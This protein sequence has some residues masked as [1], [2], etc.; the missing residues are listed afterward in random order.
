MTK[1]EPREGIVAG[2]HRRVSERAK[3]AG[4]VAQVLADVPMQAIIDGLLVEAVLEGSDAA[5][6]QA[7][8][9]AIP[10]GILTATQRSRTP[11]PLVICRRAE[12]LADSVERSLLLDA[13]GRPDDGSAAAQRLWQAYDRYAS[14]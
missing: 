1:T 11:L 14:G 3:A 7:A 5:E 4:G 9:P 8:L 13:E 2:H 6:G 10:V 12:T